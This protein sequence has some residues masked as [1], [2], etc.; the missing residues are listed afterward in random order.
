MN[1]AEAQILTQFPEAMDAAVNEKFGAE[2]ECKSTFNFF[3]SMSY[4]STFK[5]RGKK[6]TEIEAYIAGYI[7][8]NLELRNR[9]QNVGKK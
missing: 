4:T 5:A 2:V 8:G 3:G 1:K 7:A 9:L 6:K